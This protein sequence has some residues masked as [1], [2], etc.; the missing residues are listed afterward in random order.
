MITLL[1]YWW[2]LGW[3]VE[4]NKAVC[5]CMST[6][7]IGVELFVTFIILLFRWSNKQCQYLNL[8]PL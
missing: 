8:L 1:C 2:T 4:F 5:A 6:F 3:N 7:E